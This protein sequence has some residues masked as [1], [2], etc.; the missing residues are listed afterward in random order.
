MFSGF[1]PLSRALE[2]DA[3]GTLGLAPQALCLRLL[4]RLRLRNRLFVQSP[5]NQLITINVFRQTAGNFF[6]NWRTSMKTKAP[7][8][9]LALLL[10]LPFSALAQKNAQN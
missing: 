5:R 1:R 3:I 10:L 2:L 8:L 9:L 7:L 6:K 4:R